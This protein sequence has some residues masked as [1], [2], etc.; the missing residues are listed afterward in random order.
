MLNV[1]ISGSVWFLN[2][3]HTVGVLRCDVLRRASIIDNLRIK[4][5]D[6]HGRRE[7]AIEQQSVSEDV[8]YII[9]LS[10]I[11]VLIWYSTVFIMA[12]N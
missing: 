6:S 3:Q 7:I 10:H 9:L 5:D 12:A 2:I 1:E 4:R 11:A 8:Q